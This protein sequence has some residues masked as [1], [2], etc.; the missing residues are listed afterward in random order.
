MK[1]HVSSVI[2]NAY[3]KG[4]KG[5]DFW[6]KISPSLEARFGPFNVYFSRD[7]HSAKQLIKNLVEK[8]DRIFISAGGD[9]GINLLI[10]TIIEN[11]GENPLSEFTL[12]AVGLGSSND[13]HKP[14]K[15][16]IQG[17]PV[18]LNDTK[19]IL[20]DVGEVYYTDQNGQQ[21]EKYFLVSA[22]AGIVARGNQHF[23]SGGLIINLIKKR[24]TNL[25]IIYTFFKTLLSYQ[26]I[27][28]E[29]ILDDIERLQHNTSYLAISKTP[30]ISGFIHFNEDVPKDN[31]NFMVKILYDYSK[32]G[33]VRGFVKLSKGKEKALSNII[34]RSVKKIKVCSSV[35][36]VLEYDG[37]TQITVG[38]RFQMYKEKINECT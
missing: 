18:R 27:P 5:I 11:K 35:P 2:V 17:V 34:T 23:N 25:A 7:K 21:R 22:S 13:F 15:E 24:S 29:L 30:Y 6:K 12:G 28:F 38:A 26:N 1:N 36:F 19:S 9:G 31:G 37:E 14:I 8:G 32:M 3:C 10:N 16:K 33:L 4:G 20:R